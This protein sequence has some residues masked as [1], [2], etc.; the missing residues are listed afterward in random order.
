MR[1]AAA[2]RDPLQRARTPRR[3]VARPW[4]ALLIGSA[5][6]LC[7]AALPSLRNEAD[8]GAIRHVAT[9]API[10][11]VASRYVDKKKVCRRARKEVLRS[12]QTGRDPDWGD[13]FR[14]S[15][16]KASKR[17]RHHQPSKP[18]PQHHKKYA[19]S[20]IPSGTAPTT[21]A[22]GRSWPSNRAPVRPSPGMPTPTAKEPLNSHQ[23]EPAPAAR[24]PAPTPTST[25]RTDPDRRGTWGSSRTGACALVLLLG[26]AVF[27]GRYRRTVAPA[28]RSPITRVKTRPQSVEVL[29][30][31]T[32]TDHSSPDPTGITPF[33]TTGVSLEGPAAENAV[34]RLVM[35][36]LSTRP[37]TTTELVLSRPDA[38]RLLGID[39]GNLLE[40]RVP[41]LVLTEA[42]E[43]TRAY[44]TR[45]AGPCRILVTYD[46]EAEF[47]EFPNQAQLAVISLSPPTGSMVGAQGVEAAANVVAPSGIDRLTPLSKDGAFNQL[48]S[49]PT[50]ARPSR[51]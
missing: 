36:V 42:L 19:M 17:P 44:L 38:W 6:L 32:P 23:A 26:V 43:Q 28:A 46:G 49:M 33:T 10:G 35:E 24:Q 12:L 18:H 21:G 11:P 45:Q 39:L 40:D 16:P 4:G 14:D 37:G 48:M 30:P 27:V 25:P 1:D 51:Q 20:P 31:P 7:S 5:A 2:A 47:R 9:C 3:G 22:A 8:P 50:I 34:R 41:G 29:E 15:I 13:V